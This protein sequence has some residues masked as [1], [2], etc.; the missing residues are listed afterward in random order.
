M[1][2]VK[3]KSE[4]V[5]T[6]NRT[7]SLQLR[8][9]RRGMAKLK[10]SLGILYERKLAFIGAILVILVLFTA[11]FTSFITPSDPV[12]MR[13]KRRLELPSWK[14]PL[15]L[16][17]FGRDVWSRIAY[18]TR[19]SLKVSVISVFIGLFLGVP[20]GALAGYAGGHTD[21]ILMRLMDALLAFPAILL[22]IT[23]VA[24]LGSSIINIMIAIG[25]V[26]APIFSRITRGSVLSEKEKEYVEAARV[27]GESSFRIL[28][29]EILPNALSPI[30]VQGT[31]LF[32]YAILV[33]SALSFIGLGVAPPTPSW[34]I[35][36]SEA[37]E[38]MEYYPLQTIFPGIAISLTVFGF[39]LL[40]DGLRDILDPRLS[41]EKGQQ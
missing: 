16:D 11:V 33:E 15:G 40:G 23:I 25:I 3:E 26:Y 32:A 8:T 31:I 24:V 39:N 20:V 13:M 4:D 19:V 6:G 36:L 10:T 17:Q 35:M 12:E 28:F 41:Q 34:G 7:S 37:A 2:L 5:K 27:S 22:A 21:N 14:H 29:C 38:F 9:Q 1:A 18:G 30:I